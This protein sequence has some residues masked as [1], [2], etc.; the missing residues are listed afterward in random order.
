[1]IVLD[2]HSAIW[3]TQ[4]PELLSARAATALEGEDRI[5]IPAI[6]FWET[7]LLVRKGRLRLRGVPS[8]R[9]WAL[10]VLSI[11]RVL[12]APLTPAIATAADGLAMHPDPA[13]RFVAATAIEYDAPLLTK[14]S[15][16]HG[17]EWLNTVW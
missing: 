5:V 7:S 15:L 16:L 3:W 12:A 1:M 4:E 10:E 13:D 2:T 6:V 14:D 11:P 8:A 9:D 17:L